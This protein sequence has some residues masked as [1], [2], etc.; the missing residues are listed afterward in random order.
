M[1]NP[2]VENEPPEI[3]ALLRNK[4]KSGLWEFSRHAVDRMIQRN[5][6]VSEVR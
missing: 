2:G 1:P 3:I 5:I 6:S 4:V